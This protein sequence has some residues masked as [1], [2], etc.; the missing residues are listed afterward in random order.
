MNIT[1]RVGSAKASLLL[2]IGLAFVFFYA[3]IASFTESAGWIG[4][5]PPFLQYFS[6]LYAFAVVE[7]VLGLWL[8]IGKWARVAAVIAA[9]MLAGIIVFNFSSMDVI[10]RDVGL[11]FA[12]LALVIIG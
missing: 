11:F 5:L 8:L 1:V 10:F 3:G 4:F 6:V 12:A 7:I 9:L 2:R